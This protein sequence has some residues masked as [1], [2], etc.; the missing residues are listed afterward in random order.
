MYYYDE[1]FIK[2]NFGK[3]EHFQVPEG[4]FDTLRSRV[5]NDIK[6]RE[7]GIPKQPA[8]T[9]SIWY[10]YRAA[11]VS[12]AAS[13]LIGGFALGAWMHGVGHAPSESK[14]TTSQAM[15]SS[16][17]LDAMMNYSMMD[18]EDMYSYMADAE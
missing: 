6:T 10:R 5:L 16:S 8:R 14:Q 18:T 7:A 1:H 4:Y 17:N 9:I 11:V 12:A 3:E 2:K 13:V 15:T